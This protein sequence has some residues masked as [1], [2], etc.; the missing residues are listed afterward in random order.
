MKAQT[1]GLAKRPRIHDL[2]HTN[3]SWL[4]HAGLNIYMLQKHLGHKSITT[5]LDRYSHLLPEGL[6]DTTAAMNRAFG[7][8]AS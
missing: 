1:K 4:L 6:H 3:A 2:R 5:T 8:R 7:S